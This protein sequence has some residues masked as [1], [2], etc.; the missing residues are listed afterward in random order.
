[1]GGFMAMGK[2]TVGSMLASELKV[3]FWD[4]DNEIEK[5]VGRSVAAL[6]EQRGEAYFRSV[7]EVVVREA[8][9]SAPAVIALGGGALHWNNNYEWIRQRGRLF[10]LLG[11]WSTVAER[12]S[13]SGRP[14]ADQAKVLFDQRKELYER[15]GTPI[16]VDNLTPSEVC[17]H[18][19]EQIDG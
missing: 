16:W 6:F 8:L 3:Q 2:T 19:I 12:I 4:T 9:Q 5:R 17:H 15:L 10:V 7:E 18:I 14:L 1:M 11:E 13:S